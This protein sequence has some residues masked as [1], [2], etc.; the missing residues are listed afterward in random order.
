M[1]KQSILKIPIKISALEY[2]IEP[3]AAAITWTDDDIMVHTV[4]E[5]ESGSFDSGFIQAG[6]NWDHTFDESGEYDYYCTLHPWMKCAVV[7][8]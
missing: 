2:P 7:V 1:K 5:Q 6:A 8:R 4:T 3:D